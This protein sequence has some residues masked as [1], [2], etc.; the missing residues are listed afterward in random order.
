MGK[1]IW[2]DWA[3]LVS[4]SASIYLF[5]AAAWGIFYRKFFFDF[6]HH[7][8]SSDPPHHP[9]PNP[10]YQPVMD[11]IITVPLVQLFAM[12]LALIAIA[13][14]YPIPLMKRSFANRNFTFKIV[15]LLFQA[16]LA[17]LFYQGTNGFLWSIIGACG[18][19]MAIRRG[20]RMENESHDASL[21]H[22]V[23]P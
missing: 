17:L 10:R 3:R 21:R 18:Y 12:V 20:E 11:I 14:E 5:W 4:I 9:T 7:G 2:H 8:Y 6:I 13:F 16:S 19:A 1:F 22:V 23:N 15:W